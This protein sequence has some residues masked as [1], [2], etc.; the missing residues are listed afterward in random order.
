VRGPIAE[1]DVTG[2]G[3]NNAQVKPAPLT[4]LIKS[5]TAM[6]WDTGDSGPIG[7]TT[8]ATWLPLTLTVN[9]SGTALHRRN[10]VF[11]GG[12]PFFQLPPG[13]YGNNKPV[14]MTT[15]VQTWKNI[16]PAASNSPLFSY[17]GNLRFPPQQGDGVQR[18]LVRRARLTVHCEDQQQ[19]HH[20][21]AR[22]AC[23][24]TSW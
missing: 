18:R 22:R 6:I 15:E 10:F 14:N 17:Q 2:P 21:A 23:A 8:S 24:G 19:S 3:S 20:E 16:D 7:R 4:R 5:E 12:D 11:L 13:T 1:F 9:A